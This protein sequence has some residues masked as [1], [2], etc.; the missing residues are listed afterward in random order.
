[1]KKIFVF[2]AVLLVSLTSS[3]ALDPVT[4]A[5]RHTAGGTVQVEVQLID[6]STTTNVY[7][8][9]GNQLIGNLSA[10]SNGI[11]TFKVG[12]G[13]GAWTAITPASVTNNYMLAVYAGGTIVRFYRL[14]QLNLEQSKWAEAILSATFATTGGVT[15]N[16]EGTYSSDDFVFGSPQLADDG[17]SDHD[18]RMFFDKSKSA[19][20]AGIVQG[21]Q[22]D[23]ANIGYYSFAVGYDNTASEYASTVAGGQENTSSGISS[24]VSGGISNTASGEYSTVS[25]GTGN[26]AN[27][28]YSAVSGGSGNTAS[29]EY[30]TVNGGNDNFASEQYCTIGGGY[31]NT[32]SNR[33]ST[34]SGGISNAASGLSSTVS[35]GISNI[36]SRISSTVSGGISNTAGGEYSIVAGGS[37]NDAS[38]DYSIVCGGYSNTANGQYNLVFGNN[39]DP[40]VTEDYRVYF[41]NGGNP[42]M[43]AIN[44][45]DAD[46][47]IHV[48]TNA[49]NGNGAHLTA[50][51]IW[52]NTSSITKKDRFEDL[53][54]NI[55]NSIMQLPIKKWSYKNTNERHIGP[56][57]EDFYRLFG[58]GDLNNIDANQYL[59]TMDVA[60]VSLRG[61]QVLIEENRE[62]KKELNEMK[63]MIEQLIEKME[64]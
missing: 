2:I 14:D 29:G 23:D 17:D 48:G 45:E 22:W 20:R 37:F 5:F 24:T 13:D 30:S 26:A 1:M 6:Y 52:T 3:Q 63:K 18:S 57:A 9:A 47:P 19:F 33:N 35:G 39:V 46:H 42:G 28:D 15:S 41:F 32:T 31:A 4:C 43:L 40:V 10:N 49:S 11:V 38:G 62:L 60:G 8:G 54:D 51:G 53:D 50:G 12:E 27:G 36:A 55:L 56:F 25:G 21:N 44:R 34:V 16:S 58:T 61:V 7:P 64:E 59:S